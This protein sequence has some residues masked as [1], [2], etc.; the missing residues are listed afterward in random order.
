MKG[1]TTIIHTQDE[2]FAKLLLSLNVLRPK[3]WTPADDPFIGIRA[4]VHGALP[5]DPGYSLQSFEVSGLRTSGRDERW[6]IAYKPFNHF[7]ATGQIA[8]QPQR[9]RRND[10]LLLTNWAAS[11]IWHSFGSAMFIS[12]WYR[13]I[14]TRTTYCARWKRWYL[15]LFRSLPLD[16]D[17]TKKS[18]T[19]LFPQ[20][21]EIPY[22]F[23]MSIPQPVRLVFFINIAQLL[24]VIGNRSTVLT[25]KQRSYYIFSAQWT[26]VFH[27]SPSRTYRWPHSPHTTSLQCQCQR[28]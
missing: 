9:I 4:S 10:N 1:A 15:K 5:V 25:Q 17:P 2:G 21:P 3:I 7:M 13:Q 22:I 18:A 12:V 11:Q 20:R 23:H 16:L 28:W 8:A 6:F 19:S 14:A 26:L 24:H 27:Q